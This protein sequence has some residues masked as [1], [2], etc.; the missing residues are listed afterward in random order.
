MSAMSDR[1]IEELIRLAVLFGIDL[2]LLSFVVWRIYFPRHRNREFVFTAYVI[3]TVT[4]A[5]CILMRKHTVEA[6]FGL[7]LF[8]VFSILRYRTQEIATRELSY[9]FVAIG[10]ALANSIAGTSLDSAIGLAIVNLIIVAVVAA[11]ERASTR[12]P[13]A[14]IPVLYDNLPLLAPG[15]ERELAEDLN[16]RLGLLVRKVEVGRLDLLRD[17]AEITVHYRKQPGA[18]ENRS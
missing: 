8:G 2:V 14:V 4:F 15:R 18:L 17:A 6:S 12:D 13:D 11:L 1:Q 7:G 16:K 9:L 3:N 5:V 10:L